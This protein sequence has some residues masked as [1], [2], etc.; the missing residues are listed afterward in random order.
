MKQFFKI[1]SCLLIVMAL[2]VSCSPLIN[3]NTTDFT[4]GKVQE[5]V[6]GKDGYTAK[7]AATDNSIYLV[8]ISRANLF[9]PTQYRQVSTGETIQVKGD[10]F[11]ISGVNHMTV[12]VL[13]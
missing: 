10:V 12:R 5:I 7:L 9:E 4:T 11:K 13:K 8:T 1:A 2:A 3:A 6:A